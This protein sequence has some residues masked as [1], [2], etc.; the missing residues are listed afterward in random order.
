M[1]RPRV[2]RIA[3]I[4]G[5]VKGCVRGNLDKLHRSF[6]AGAETAGK[7]GYKAA[8]CA[9]IRGTSVDQ[10]WRVKSVRLLNVTLSISNTQVLGASLPLFLGQQV[11]FDDKLGHWEKN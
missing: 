11:G 7:K 1:S 5:W 6:F 3:L 4:K 9:T 10:L 2:Y 8:Y